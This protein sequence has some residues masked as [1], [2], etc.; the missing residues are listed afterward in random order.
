MKAPNT[1]AVK[2]SMALT[3]ME[4]PS[5][6]PSNKSREALT[7]TLNDLADF[8]KREQNGRCDPSERPL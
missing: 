8:L 7:T 5:R 6:T 3:G 4:N 2:V 1:G